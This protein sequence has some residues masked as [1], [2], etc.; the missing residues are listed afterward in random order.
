MRDG[1]SDGYGDDLNTQLS[2]IPLTGAWLLTGGDCHDGNANI[3]P[4][5]IE[6]MHEV[7]IDITGKR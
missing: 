6:A 2:C 7:G 4:A 3:N 5:A 1:D